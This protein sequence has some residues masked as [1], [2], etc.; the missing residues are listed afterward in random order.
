M[1]RDLQADNNIAKVNILKNRFSGETGKACNLYYD[2]KTGC[3]TEVKGEVS[4][5]F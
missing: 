3:L 4:D 1:N 2:L 5:E